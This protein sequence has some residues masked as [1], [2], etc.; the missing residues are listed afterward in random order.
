MSGLRADKKSVLSKVKVVLVLAIAATFQLTA[1]ACPYEGN[2]PRSADSL[3]QKYAKNWPQTGERCAME[4]V[5]PNLQMILGAINPDARKC[6]KSGS[7]TTDSAIRKT[8]N[9][10]MAVWLRSLREDFKD[11]KLKY[12]PAVGKSS[13]EFVV[14]TPGQPRPEAPAWPSQCFGVR[15]QYLQQIDAAIAELAGQ[16]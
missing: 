2:D 14:K 6:F 3:G 10:E 9:A 12:S 7:D 5:T 8:T 15:D 11:G 1:S 13:Y 16:K 4:Y